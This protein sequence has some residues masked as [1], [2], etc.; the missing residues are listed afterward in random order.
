MKPENVLTEALLE[1]LTYLNT[2]TSKMSEMLATGVVNNFL[3][4]G[5]ILLPAGR[6]PAGTWG[7][8]WGATCGAMKVSNPSDYP[9]VVQS[10]GFPGTV[11]QQGPGVY[12]IPPGSW[13]T[14]NVNSRV[15]A[16]YGTAGASFGYQAYTTGLTP[17]GGI[18]GTAAVS[19]FTLSGSSQIVASPPSPANG[20]IRRY[21]GLSIRETTGSAGA[22]VRVWGNTAA[23]GLLLDTIALAAGESTRE[24]YPGR[25]LAAPL[26]IYLEVVSGTIEGTVR[27]A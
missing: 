3:E 9:L 10:G 7:F 17:A 13:D 2:H 1:Q 12:I 8:S 19:A 16:V 27:Y 25:G 6:F 24:D 23:S 20:A 21:Y 22:V 15:V 5:T 11:P 26:G 4:G 18:I 14:V